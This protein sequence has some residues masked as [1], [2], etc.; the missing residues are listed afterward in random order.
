MFTITT[1]QK[2]QLNL[3]RRPK[4]NQSNITYKV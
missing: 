3:A 2:D 4:Q 1:E